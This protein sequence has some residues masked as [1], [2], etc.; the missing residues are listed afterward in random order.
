MCHRFEKMAQSLR[1]EVPMN[2]QETALKI[3]GYTESLVRDWGLVAVVVLL[4]LVSFG[5]GRFSAFEDVRPPVSILAAPSEARPSGRYMGALLVASRTGSVY[6]YPWCSG[7]QTIAAANQV[8]FS[9]RADAER[10]GYRASK[11]CKGL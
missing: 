5:L 10:A 8:W 2:I 9:S 3:K 4:G 1:I 11:S 6:Y 7:A